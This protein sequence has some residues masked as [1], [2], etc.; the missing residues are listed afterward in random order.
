MITKRIFDLVF[1]IPGLLVLCP[2][3][4]VV[5]IWIKL[6]SKGPVFFRQERVGKS[7]Q[8]F[9]IFKF[10]TMVVDAESLGAKVTVGR[11]PRIT[12]SGF[13]L[14]KYKL[15]ELPQLIN[16]LK[17]EMSLVGPRPE[18]KEYVEH[19]PEEAYDLVLSV[20]P[21]ITD[22]AS[23]EFRDENDLLTDAINPV[24]M[25]INE[26]T[27]IKLEHYKRYVRERSIFLDLRLIFRT[28]VAILR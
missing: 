16:V 23:I 13:L 10:R 11:D 26:I 5:S 9:R 8:L 12:N 1:V 24:E 4:V 18:V 22:F 7:G 25:Y 28:I 21:G 17:G 15:D 3:L 19:W 27:P 2:V 6:D 14:R 20:P